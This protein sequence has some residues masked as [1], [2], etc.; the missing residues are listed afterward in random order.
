MG[1]KLKHSEE[2]AMYPIIPVMP[3]GRGLAGRLRP[4]PLF[5]LESSDPLP[6]AKPVR[7]GAAVSDSAD[8]GAL[9]RQLFWKTA[10]NRTDTGSDICAHLF[11]LCRTLKV[12]HLDP[13]GIACSFDVEPGMLPQPVCDRLGLIVRALVMDAADHAVTGIGDKT[14]AVT[15]HRRR[16]IWAC[17]I[18]HSGSRVNRAVGPDSWRAIAEA[19]AVD[20]K[21]KFRTWSEN[22][23]TITAVCFAIDRT[24]APVTA[25]S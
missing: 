13:R 21:A 1:A 14:I 6:S 7:S 8:D 25:A 17:S 15:L 24:G 19:H 3:A 11:Q 18:A 16:A 9:P 23:G 4:K 5:T 2:L 12:E 22:G 20:L 10:G